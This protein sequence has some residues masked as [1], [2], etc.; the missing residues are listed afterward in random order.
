MRMSRVVLENSNNRHLIQIRATSSARPITGT[1][2]VLLSPHAA[3]G[4]DRDRGFGNRPFTILREYTG[5][6]PA[7][8]RVSGATRPYPVLVLA[9]A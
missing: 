6:K 2:C 8:G 4:P 1:I 7:K 5:G 9:F 3:A